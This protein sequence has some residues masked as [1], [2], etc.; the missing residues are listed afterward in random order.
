MTP[1]GRSLTRMAAALALGIL[2]FAAAPVG[3]ALDGESL[4]ALTTGR[5]WS[6]GVNQLAVFKDRVERGHGPPGGRLI[7]GSSIGSSLFLPSTLGAGDLALYYPYG[8]PGVL[9]SWVPVGPWRVVF[10]WDPQMLLGP[11]VP[12]PSR[13]EVAWE[14]RRELWRLS[15]HAALPGPLGSE[16]E[17][18][19]RTLASRKSRP[20]RKAQRRHEAAHL[21]AKMNSRGDNLSIED[22]IQGLHSWRARQGED[23]FRLVVLPLPREFLETPGS[24]VAGNLQEIRRSLAKGWDLLDLSGESVDEDAWVDWGHYEGAHPDS[25]NLRRRI[26][27]TI[28]SG[29]GSRSKPG[30]S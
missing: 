24:K 29:S 17:T 7:V 18:L 1:Q 9:E 6:Y 21:I 10:L 4:L 14:A 30:S 2:V 27:G 3:R 23:R 8:R 28:S 25:K 16:E 20:H 26:L 11:V 5:H 15:L 12:R 19:C 22:D 13:W